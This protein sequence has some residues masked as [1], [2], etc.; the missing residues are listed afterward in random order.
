MTYVESISD[1]IKYPTF[2]Y[3]DAEL[4]IIEATKDVLPQKSKEHLENIYLHILDLTDDS[5]K[6]ACL[7]KLL[8]RF[9]HLGE[10]AE[11][12]KTLGC[13]SVDIR[14][15]ITEFV[16]KLLQE[17]AYHLKVVEEP[18]KAL[19]CDYSTMIDELVVDINTDERKKRAYSLAATHYLLK[20]DEEKVS[21][22]YFFELISKTDNTY[23][24][25]E[26]PLELL[27]GML[28]YAEK[29]NHAAFLP[30]FG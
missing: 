20:Q 7:S 12:E 28:L 17:T 10:K 30:L 4:T 18:I 27:S 26:Y 23:D 13:S 15:E 24:N 8:G 21:P 14:K 9:D 1:T 3:V 19:V 5:V 2:D 29:V 16:N 11:T 25:R 22:N 6:V